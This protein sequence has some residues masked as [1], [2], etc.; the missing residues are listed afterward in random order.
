M[1]PWKTIA[2]ASDGSDEAVAAREPVARLA[3]AAGATLWVIHAVTGTGEAGE[4][5][6]AGLKDLVQD[7]RRGGLAGS[8]Y[9]VRAAGVPVAEAIAA[10]AR[11]VASDVL[12]IGGGGATV[13]GVLATAPCPVLVL[14][15]P[16]SARP[17]PPAAR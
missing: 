15:A 2:W 6:V 7:L 4:Q 3:A 17:A 11:A 8:L 1:R 14:A 10:T 16:L 12:V 13:L 9:V 5:V